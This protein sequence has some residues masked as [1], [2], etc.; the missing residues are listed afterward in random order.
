MNKCHQCGSPSY[1][2]VI[3]RDQDG[4]MRPSG[5]YQCTGCNLVFAR[6]SEWRNGEVPHKGNDH[7]QLGEFETRK[8]DIRAASQGFLFPSIESIT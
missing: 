4:V 1:K 7:A 5:Q 2:N 8:D 3:K 6:L